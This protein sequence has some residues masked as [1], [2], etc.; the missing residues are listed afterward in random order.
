MR[1]VVVENFF[2]GLDW[3]QRCDG[4]MFIAV[5]DKNLVT[6]SPCYLWLGIDKRH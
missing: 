1:P 2:P 5:V 6:I 3:S 4:E